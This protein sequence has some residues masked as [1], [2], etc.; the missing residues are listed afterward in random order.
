MIFHDSNI[1]NG[2]SLTTKLVD[3]AAEY[4]L[5]LL[6]EN[7]SP[8]YVFH[9]QRYTVQTVHAVTIIGKAEEVTLHDLFTLKRN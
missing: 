1:Q 5:D 3:R 2:F 8:Q 6:Q 9:N 7:L 4:V